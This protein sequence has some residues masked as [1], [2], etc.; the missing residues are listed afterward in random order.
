MTSAASIS[1]TSPVNTSSTT[2]AD[3][4]TECLESQGIGHIYTNYWLGYPIAFESD[5]RIVP[6]VISDGFNRY[7]PYAYYV[8]VADRPAWVFVADGEEER[9]FQERLAKAGATWK[10]ADVSIYRVY[11]DVNPVAPLRP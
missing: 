8:S 1:L 11:Y 6:S 9:A 5:E 2:A 3:G 10:R 4:V 7:I